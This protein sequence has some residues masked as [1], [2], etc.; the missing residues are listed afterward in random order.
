MIKKIIFMDKKI[1]MLVIPSDRYGVGFFRSL[2]PHQYIQEHYQDMFDIDI[3][4]DLPKDEPLDKFFGKYDIVHMHKQ[5]DKKCELINMMK[6]VG[7]KKNN[8]TCQSLNT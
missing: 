8:G 1:K 2:Q 7:C 5:L 4:Y 3:V 6:F